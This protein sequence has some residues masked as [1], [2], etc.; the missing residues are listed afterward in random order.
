MIQILNTRPMQYIPGLET[1][2]PI[3]ALKT[4]LIETRK[5]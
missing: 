5:V 3:T 2:M 4:Y 1:C